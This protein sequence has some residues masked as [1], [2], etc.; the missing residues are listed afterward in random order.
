MLELHGKVE[1]KEIL[2]P[3][4]QLA[5]RQQTLQKLEGKNI[6]EII[7]RETKKRSY[8]QLKAHFGLA[9]QKIVQEFEDRGW[10]ASMIYNFDKPTGVP[11][12]KDML[13]QF[14]YALYPTC[15]DKGER[16]TLSSEDFTTIKE[17]EFFDNIRN[18]AS[19]QWS[20]YIADPDPNY[21]EKNN[22]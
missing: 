12:N 10:D 21:R 5:L 20:I 7:K 14:F 18:H 15:N 11:V 8:L 1:N 3:R 9:L 22:D 6:V 4:D 16:I 2:L 17:M 13:Q 19:S